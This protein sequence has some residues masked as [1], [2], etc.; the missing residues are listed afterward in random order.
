MEGNG[1]DPNQYLRFAEQRRRHIDDLFTLIKPVVGGRAA[2]LGCGTGDL[3]AELHRRLGLAETVGVDSSRQM[4][5]ETAQLHIGGLHFELADMAT[6][7]GEN[8]DLIFSNAALQ[9]LPNHPRLVSHFHKSL[10]EAGQLAFQ[11]PTNRDHEAHLVAIDV[12]QEPPFCEIL[13]SDHLD[14]FSSVMEPQAY[15]ETFHHAGFT[16]QSVQLRVYTHYMKSPQELYDWVRGGL[17]VHY[18]RFMNS[19]LFEAFA[20]QYKRRLFE[21]IGESGPYLHIWKRIICWA[22]R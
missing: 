6:W 18:R 4:L 14:P 19:D 16:D 13:G 17:L 21:R 15:A 5:R 9:W 20:S 10:R 7:T 22:Q 2:D 1:W 12:A 8:Y 3:T 11:V